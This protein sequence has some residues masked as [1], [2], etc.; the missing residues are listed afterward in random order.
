MPTEA[1]PQSPAK[2]RRLKWC[3][4]Y[5]PAGIYRVIEGCTLAGV[6][7]LACYGGWWLVFG[8]MHDPRYGRMV[9]LVQLISNN[10]KAF[11]L[12]LVPLFYRST[13]T[14]MDE[15]QEVFGMKRRRTLLP[16]ARTQEENPPMS[17]P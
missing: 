14:F 13:R 9:S 5:L 17:A 4:R 7:V 15:V 2:W 8:N 3:W 11:L 16:T 10:W 6:F 12:I 1:V